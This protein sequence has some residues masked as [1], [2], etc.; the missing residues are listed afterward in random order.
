MSAQ[1]DLLNLFFNYSDDDLAIDHLDQELNQSLNEKLIRDSTNLLNA[2]QTTTRL[3]TQPNNATKPV[4]QPIN[5]STNS[6]QSASP[7]ITPNGQSAHMDGIIDLIE[8]PKISQSVPSLPHGASIKVEPTS[9]FKTTDTSIGTADCLLNNPFHTNE[10]TS[11]NAANIL[12]TAI[13]PTS[14]TSCHRCS[15]N[16]VP[17]VLSYPTT[18]LSDTLDPSTIRNTNEHTGNPQ[19]S[20]SSCVDF[21]FNSFENFCNGEITNDFTN[22][23]DPD[24]SFPYLAVNST[25]FDVQSFISTED[26]QVDVDPEMSASS[27]I[28][29]NEP[30]DYSNLS[31]FTSGWNLESEALFSMD[32]LEFGIPKEEPKVDVSS[33]QLY[34]SPRNDLYAQKATIDQDAAS[35]DLQ[36]FPQDNVSGQDI[37]ISEFMTANGEA[38]GVSSVFNKEVKEKTQ[39]QD[40]QHS[41]THQTGRQ[42]LNRQLVTSLQTARR[43]PK[44]PLIFIPRA[45]SKPRT[46]LPVVVTSNQLSKATGVSVTNLPTHQFNGSNHGPLLSQTTLLELVVPTSTLNYTHNTSRVSKSNVPRFKRPTNVPKATRDRLLK[47]INE[48]AQAQSQSCAENEGNVA[49]SQINTS[50]FTF[51][52]AL[53]DYLSQTRTQSKSMA[54]L[55][56]KPIA[57][58]LQQLAQASQ[59]KPCKSRRWNPK[60][61]LDLQ[62]PIDQIEY[63]VELAPQLTNNAKAP[64][65]NPGQ[66]M[67]K[68][69]ELYEGQKRQQLQTI[70]RTRYV[71]ARDAFLK[72][73]HRDVFYEHNEYF[74]VSRPY[75]QQFTRVE[76]E[77]GSPKNETRCALCAYCEQPSFFE[78]KNLCYAQHMSHLHGIYTDDYLAPNPVYVGRYSVAKNANPDR[79]TVARVRDHD[80]VVCP[81]CYNLSEIRCWSSTL[82][83]KPLLNYL[84]HFKECHRIGRQ[85]DSFFSELSID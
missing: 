62:Y 16:M 3:I 36:M 49:H 43:V 18:L 84:R 54:L 4:I 58:T 76:V 66:H 85:K 45:L 55:Q 47:Q 9:D 31:Q 41:A 82:K 83:Q 69:L 33:A 39:Q 72:L 46:V 65:V 25:L 24:F 64:E 13:Y 7:P 42:Q 78:L 27:A 6:A 19:R 1:T 63:W 37:D 29:N 71:R 17:N 73:Q 81:V 2:I 23:S 79:K 40:P 67:D 75:Q 26:I 12:D 11:C 44:Q 14:P 8:Y 21:G 32:D 68:C 74:D 28:K 5:L 60:P 70:V 53:C 61:K 52:Q 57:K 48:A 50:R 10:K 20:D 56:F 77:N 30:C 59:R 22:F 38:L 34:F 80:C 15:P 35:S 51:P